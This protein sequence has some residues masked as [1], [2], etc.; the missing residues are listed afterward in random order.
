MAFAIARGSNSA[1]AIPRRSSPPRKEWIK[2]FDPNKKEDA[3]HLLEALWLH[4]QHNVKNLELLQPAPE[5]AWSRTPASPRR[6]CSISGSTS[7]RPLRGGVIAE[8]A[9]A[10]AQKSGILSDTPELTTIRI[11]TMPERMM[12]DV[13]ELT[14]KPG[15][16]VKLTFANPDFMP[17]NILLV[18][19]G[20][21][22]E[23]GL[24]AIALGA[25]GFEVG[26]VPESPDILWH[27]KLVDHGQEEVIEFTAPT[28]EGPTR[29]SARSPGTTASCAARS[30]SRTTC[31]DFLA[32]NPQKR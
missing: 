28:A 10:T 4:Q 26:F 15:K 14:V 6:P 5:F 21:A 22:D 19:P 13:K 20:K 29:M 30:S 11:A 23:V 16:K 2:Q 1:A 9:E 8:A 31:K 25:R 32:K 18:K 24:K 12:Y 27:S 17:H 7:R 3:H